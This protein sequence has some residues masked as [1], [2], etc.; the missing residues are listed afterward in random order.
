[1][2]VDI[3]E[4]KK[5][6]GD[7]LSGLG[8][9]VFYQDAGDDTAFPYLVFNLADSNFDG[10]N[11]EFFTLDIDGWTKG[12]DA[13]ALTTLMSKVD[14][15]LNKNITIINNNLSFRTV[16]DRRLSLNDSDND[17]LRWK[18]QFQLRLFR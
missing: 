15:L 8:S 5:K 9:E 6:L 7:L 14:A 10:A 4:I 12:P 16:F 3:L 13:T 11:S 17:I 18:Y 2:I 1:M